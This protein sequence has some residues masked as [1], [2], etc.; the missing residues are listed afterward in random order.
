MSNSRQNNATRAGVLTSSLFASGTFKNVYAGVYTVGERVGQRCVA[1][2]FKTG[3]VCEEHYFDEEMNVM[4]RA[5]MVIDAWH[6]G[7]FID[8]RILLNMPGIWAYENTGVKTL[9]EP[10]IENY[11][12][13]NSNTGWA[14][15]TGGAWSQVMQALS[16][17]SYHST[18]GQFLLCDLQG[19][20]YKDG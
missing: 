4:D 3:P 17:F 13:F 20:P 16:H 15:I 5:L 8:K 7:G 6:D 19:G 18:G 1:K 14:N 11:E 12:K 2:E 9:V 10:M